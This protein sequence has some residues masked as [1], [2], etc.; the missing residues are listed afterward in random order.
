MAKKKGT[1]EEQAQRARFQLIRSMLRRAW[2]RDPERFSV[3]HAAKRPYIGE[4]KRQKNEFQCAEC[5]NW[6]PQKLVQVD[7]LHDAGTFLCPADWATF[8]PRLFCSREHLQVL[9]KNCHTI[10]TNNERKAKKAIQNN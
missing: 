10:K 8:G 4:N 1:E 5:L 6:F 3:L 2:S 7:H 9:C